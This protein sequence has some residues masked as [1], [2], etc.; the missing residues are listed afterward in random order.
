MTIQEILDQ[1]DFVNIPHIEV[2]KKWQITYFKTE[3]AEIYKEYDKQ[4]RLVY[5]KNN[6]RETRVKYT[7]KWLISYKYVDW[8]ETRTKYDSKGRITKQYDNKWIMKKFRYNRQWKVIW[9]LEQWPDWFAIEADTKFDRQWRMT[10]RKLSTGLRE[11][12]EYYPNKC[13]KYHNSNEEIEEKTYDK[14]TRTYTTRW[15]DGNISIETLDKKWDIIYS[16]A[17]WYKFIKEWDIKL[18]IYW[19]DFYLNW[20]LLQWEQSVLSQTSNN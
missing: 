11:K 1:H 9:S 8:Y 17:P 20:V 10:Y 6:E 4:W 19:V 16:E 5:E 14:K 18:E 13:Y 12:R 2:N 15:L 7:L 3:L